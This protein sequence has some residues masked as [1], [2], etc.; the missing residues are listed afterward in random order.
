MTLLLV[1]HD[2]VCMQ[3]DVFGAAEAKQTIDTNFRGTAAVTEAMLPF[4]RL[5]AA[6]EAEASAAATAA[7]AGQGADS[8]LAS[9]SS[10]SGAESSSQ[11]RQQ[12]QQQGAFAPRIINVCSQAGRLGQVAPPMQVREI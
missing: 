1:T 2:F 6:G 5:S 8:T 3:G 10:S 12:G 4:L 11:P 7:S 9:S